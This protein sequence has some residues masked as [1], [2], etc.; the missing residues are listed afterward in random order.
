MLAQSQI[1]LDYQR[2]FIGATGLPL[3][4]HAPEMFRLITYPRKLRNPFCALMATAK[5]GC[6]ACYRLQQQLE[7]QAR[8]RPKTLKCFAGLCESAVP[9]RIG[10]KVVAFLHTGQ[11]RLQSTTRGGFNRI[12]SRLLKWGAEV[13][14]KRAEEAYFQTR[15]LSPAQYQSLIRLL[16]VF[17]SHLAACGNQLLLRATRAEP[18]GVT[19]ARAFI[20]QSYAEPLSLKQVAR[21]VNLSATHFSR[22]F[23]DAVGIP[24][25][26]Y[27]ARVRIEKAKNLLQ[28]P[29]L[30]ISTL[31]FDAGFNSLSQF[32]RAFKR[33]V[34][35]SP[36]AFRHQRR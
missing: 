36:S 2:A 33:V 1:Y 14:L 7:Q 28:N 18:G 22:L 35:R 17:A 3:D 34:G 6:A 32:N 4:L 9:V 10:E 5:A 15:V 25:V 16:A 29:S 24:F 30:T 12:A 20:D 8:V 26:E 23:K 11:I 13:D 27:V 21:T 31:A 19:R